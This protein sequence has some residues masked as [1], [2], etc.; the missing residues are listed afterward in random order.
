[1][2]AHGH[3]AFI[4]EKATIRE[5]LV[6]LEKVERAREREDCLRLRSRERMLTAELRR[7]RERLAPAE[8]LF[9]PEG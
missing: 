5:L 7:R 6:E 3:P 9:H 4:L 8:H 2:D 1:M